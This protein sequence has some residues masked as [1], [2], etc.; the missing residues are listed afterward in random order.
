MKTFIVYNEDIGKFSSDDTILVLG[1]K[2]DEKLFQTLMKKLRRE[3][4]IRMF[5]DSSEVVLAV[6]NDGEEAVQDQLT[7]DKL[8]VFEADYELIR[9]IVDLRN[10]IVELENAKRKLSSK[11]SAQ[12]RKQL[13]DK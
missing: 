1:G 4:R 13:K 8:V 7:Y 6:Y 12:L 11:W 10:E 9:E 5:S 2:E 3:R